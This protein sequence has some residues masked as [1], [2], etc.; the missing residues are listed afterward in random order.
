MSPW[1]FVAAAV[2]MVSG[3]TPPPA[4]VDSQRPPQLVATSLSDVDADFADQGEYW[5]DVRAVDGRSVPFGLQVVALG[6]GHF[7]AIGYQGGLPGNGWDRETMIPW[8][9]GRQAERLE[10]RGPRGTVIIQAGSGRVLDATGTEV[11]QVQKVR[12]TSTTLGAAPPPSAIVLFDGSG[13]T[14]FD[15]GRLTPEGW[16]APGAVTKLPV[17][18]FQLHLEFQTPYMPAARDQ[19][20]GNSGIYVQ[21]R[22]EVQILDSFGLPPLF[23]G[24]GALY[25]Q[26]SPELNMSFPPLSWQ[27]Y[28]IDFTA[29]RWDPEGNKT[30]LARITIMHNGVPIHRQYPLSTKT[31]AGQPETLYDGPLLF[32]DHGNPVQFRNVWL[33]VR[34]AASEPGTRSQAPANPAADGN[35]CESCGQ[36]ALP[37]AA[38][39]GPT[40]RRADGWWLWQ[41]I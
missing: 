4:A 27:T 35:P 24:C 25:R 15:A 29:A 18:D 30:A 6:D 9:G 17:R 21:R 41:G 36:V 23:N 34:D 20:R 5:G 10:F 8:D 2:V 37:A 12:R 19:A 39:A 40:G 1:L 32:Q 7:S 13:V 22:Y 14:R 3:Q 28:D 26:Q 16:L 31:G 38:T 33:V 11:G